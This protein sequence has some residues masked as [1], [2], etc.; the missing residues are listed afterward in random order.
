[1]G[2]SSS[3]SSEALPCS[4]AWFLAPVKQ[5][6]D[7][8]PGEARK[9]LGSLGP[10]NSAFLSICTCLTGPFEL[11]IWIASGPRLC[12]LHWLTRSQ[13]RNLQRSRQSTNEPRAMSLQHGGRNWSLQP[14]V[15]SV[16][17]RCDPVF[18]NVLSRDGGVR[19]PEP[20]LSLL[21][22]FDY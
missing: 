21:A 18:P 9:A 3:S 16:M 1:M 8:D 5:R 4:R 22:G 2:P 7:W 6:P 13:K 20:K 10:G 14:L 15:A 11:G 12:Q 19:N 17:R